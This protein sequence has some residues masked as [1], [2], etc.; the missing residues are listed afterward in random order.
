M[1]S[2]LVRHPNLLPD[3]NSEGTTSTDLVLR[4]WYEHTVLWHILLYPKLLSTQSLKPLTVLKDG[5]GV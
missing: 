5:Q 4:H 1:P 2:L 3:E